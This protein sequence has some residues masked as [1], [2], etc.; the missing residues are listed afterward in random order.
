MFSPCTYFK[1][2]VI[3][4]SFTEYKDVD[5]EVVNDPNTLLHLDEEI[6]QLSI[7]DDEAG[8]SKK[9]AKSKKTKKVV[10]KVES[11]SEEEEEDENA[12]KDIRTYVPMTYAL[13]LSSLARI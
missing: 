4:E 5:P 10:K 6:S 11:S 8:A 2:W 13:S 9:G 12:G 3:T 1:G 7:E